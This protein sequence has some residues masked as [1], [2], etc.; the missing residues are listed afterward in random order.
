MDQR[1]LRPGAPQRGNAA[2]SW[3]LYDEEVFER[4]LRIAQDYGVTVFDDQE[5][6]F[7]HPSA[8][9]HYAESF[10]Q[11]MRD[12][13]PV[14][15]IVAW[16]IAVPPLSE[17]ASCVWTRAS[18]ASSAQIDPNVEIG[19]SQSDAAIGC[20]R[21][22]IDRWLAESVETARERLREQGALVPGEEKGG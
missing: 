3:C 18:D 19:D 15:R 2:N 14:G 9:V 13:A 8:S 6:L 21:A 4:A 22:K 12:S 7:T 17:L 5:S 11:R 1:A 16:R 20:R 10:E